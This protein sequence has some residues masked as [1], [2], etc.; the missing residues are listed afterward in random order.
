MF[1]VMRHSIRF[2]GRRVAA[3]RLPRHTRDGVDTHETVDVVDATRMSR[4][5]GRRDVAT[6]SGEVV[7]AFC[8]FSSAGA[9]EGRGTI[10]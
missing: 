7:R 9:L 5:V 3:R 8:P 2:S 10:F 6:R 1:S 4:A